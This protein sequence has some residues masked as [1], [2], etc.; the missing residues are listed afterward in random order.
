MKL[1]P[2]AALKREFRTANKIN[3]A[4]SAQPDSGTP[5]PINLSKDDGVKPVVSTQLSTDDTNDDE[6]I[7]AYKPVVEPI[8]PEPPEPEPPEPYQPLVEPISPVQSQTE[9]D[10]VSMPR[11]ITDQPNIDTGTHVENSNMSEPHSPYQPVIEPIS[12]VQCDPDGKSNTAAGNTSLAQSD[13]KVVTTT[14]PGSPPLTPGR[15]NE[16]QNTDC[17]DTEEYE[18]SISD[19]DTINGDN[20]P[21]DNEPVDTLKS[22]NNLM[23][24]VDTTVV[25]I[26]N[27]PT[28]CTTNGENES[29]HLNDDTSCDI[30]KGQ[31]KD[32]NIDT[33][34]CN[35]LTAAFNSKDDTDMNSHN[36]NE[37]TSL[38]STENRVGINSSPPSSNVSNILDETSLD[39]SHREIRVCGTVKVHSQ[40]LDLWL[41]EAETQKTYVSVP[42]LSDKD[43]QRWINP[44]SAKPS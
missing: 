6:T 14:P 22:A 20:I 19:P 12:P 11:M 16:R 18:D 31:N 30:M 38:L 13:D 10:N 42:K 9:Q 35:T 29:S 33:N 44:A 3:I 26:I 24:S 21:L 27:V 17:V 15:D 5:S 37:S 34:G 41:Y 43:I 4:Q 2:F 25:N 39:D 1:R 32:P 28:Q 36:N 40:I 23:S 8:T 7:E